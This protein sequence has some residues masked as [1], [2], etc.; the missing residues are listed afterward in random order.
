[1]LTLVSP[2]LSVSMMAVALTQAC[3]KE[4]RPV[5]RVVVAVVEVLEVA[6]RVIWDRAEATAGLH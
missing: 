2:F 5:S 1:M 6:K 4:P 3:E